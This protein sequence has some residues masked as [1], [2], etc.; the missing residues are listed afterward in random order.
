MTYAVCML[1]QST[2][3]CMYKYLGQ[4]MCHHFDMDLNIQ[5]KNERKGWK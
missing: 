5:L 4:H 1:N 2:V 3:M